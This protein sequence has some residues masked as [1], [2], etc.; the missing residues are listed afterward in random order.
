MPRL[1]TTLS[2]RSAKMM[3]EVAKNPS[4][5]FPKE[6]YYMIRRKGGNITV[7]PSYQLGDE[8]SKTYGHFH[9][10]EKKETYRI[11][12]GEA[13]MLIQ[14]GTDPV[15]EIRLVR[16]KEGENFTVPKGYA[17]TLINIG[18]KPVVTLDDHDPKEGKNDYLPIKKKKG[19]GYYIV[20]G[21]GGFKAVPNKRYTSLPS[22]KTDGR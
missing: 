4:A 3:R 20:K 17:H 22:L 5:V 16:L 7:L 8:Y 21:R 14:R 6:L 11:L 9:I 13:L 10:P 1:E 2:I 12:L 15:E 19:F 18:K